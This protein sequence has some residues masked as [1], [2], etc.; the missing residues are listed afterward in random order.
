MSHG[1][2]PQR[3]AGDGSHLSGFT[4][5][6]SPLLEEVRK[7]NFEKVARLMDQF[8]VGKNNSGTVTG[9]A[10]QQRQRSIKNSFQT[11]HA[12]RQRSGIERS[13][14]KFTENPDYPGAVGP[15]RHINVPKQLILYQLSKNVD[16]KMIENSI[17]HSAIAGRSQGR[18]G[19]PAL[20]RPEQ[21][22]ERSFLDFL[23]GSVAGADE[24]GQ[25]TLDAQGGIGTQSHS[26]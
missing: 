19:L 4:S 26:L 7:N 18:P 10:S 25:A 5:N 16:A 24:R 2:G 21:R 12:Q 11:A 13:S 8:I 14:T 1:V 6:Q 3:A 20:G 9:R 17:S 23:E 22:L 15:K